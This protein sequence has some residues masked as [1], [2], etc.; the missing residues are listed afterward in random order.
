LLGALPLVG[1]ADDLA[2]I[3]TLLDRVED[4]ASAV[5]VSGAGGS[6]KTRICE[7]LA[8]RA[9]R[10]GW[11]VATGRAYPVEQG[12][13]FALFS[14]AFVEVLKEM[15]QQTLSVL[16]RG[17]E[18]ELRYL[19]P[20]LGEA[21]GGTSPTGF[22]DPDEL[23]TRV[24]WNFTEFLKRYAGRSPLLVVLE[25]LQ[26]ADASS[27]ELLHF[28]ARQASGHSLLFACTY[29]DTERDASSDLVR[30]ERSLLSLGQARVHKLEPLEPEH[31][32]ELVRRV[33][34]VDGGLVGE[35]SAELF[36]WTRG[37]PFFVE[38]TLKSLVA[39]GV[40]SNEKGTWVGWDARDFA[41]AESVRDAVI[42]RW[43]GFSENARAVGEL[44][45]VV[46]ARASYPLL[47]SISGLDE[48]A[49]L[50]ALEELVDHHIL[51]ELP[52]AGA[53]V[54]DFLHP[55]VRDT[56]YQEFGLQRTRLLHAAVAEAM[57]S[58]WGEEAMEHAEELA[59]HFARTD[60]ATLTQ[61]AVVYLTAAGRR[62]RARHAD[63]EAIAYFRAALDRVGRPESPED[64]DLARKLLGGLA[65]AHLRLGE[66]ESSASALRTACE[67]VDP[68]TAEHASL[69]RTLSLATFWCGRHKEALGLLEAALAS[70]KRGG[71]KAGWVRLRLVQGHCLQE[72][73]RGREARDNVRSALPEAEAL[74]DAE[75]LARV[76]RSLAMLA[77]WLGPPREAERSAQRAI[78]L[79]KEAG[80]LTIEFGARYSLGV[81]WGMTG[82]TTRMSEAIAEARSLAERLRSPVLRIWVAEL[83]IELA[84]ATGDWD[85][86][87]ALGEQSIALARTLNQSI[88][89][90]RV[91]VLTSLFH[92]GRGDF[93]RGKI[94]VD[95][96]CELSGLN[97]LDD[98]VDVNQVVPTFTGLATYKLRVG[99]YAGAIETAKRGMEVAEGTGYDLWFLHRLLPVLAEAC[100][101]AGEIDEAE[102]VGK[103]LRDLATRM[104]HRLGIAWADTCDALVQWK[105]GDI[106][107]GASAMREAAEK[108]EAI[109]MVPAAIRIRRQLAGRLAELGDTEGSMVEIRRVHDALARLGAELELEKARIQF[110]EIGLRPPPRGAGEGP[111][112]LTEREL[113]ISRLVARRKSNKAIGRELG[114]SDRTVS[115]H[116]SNIFQKLD[117][118]N[119][120]ELGDLIRELGLLEE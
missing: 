104:N 29:D 95:E 34:E 82:D 45:A 46:G 63:R 57:E 26:W 87:V 30:V 43:A 40:L 75:L 85:A 67:G 2:S 65:R 13:P 71:D 114:I 101:W 96:A 7:E 68:G 25:D 42:T 24:F 106:E 81:L 35:F 23:R 55:V 51:V 78:E 115:T 79:A 73:G 60:A 90:P 76:H 4:G 9:K 64:R 99:D 74:G 27:L 1:R 88:L 118:S 33:F 49:L 14:D 61:K 31:V 32:T 58:F 21:E 86:G 110:R 98:S 44:A 12:V 119:R 84:F 92:L 39:Q 102:T 53:V 107:G 120:T 93:D 41:L 83:A 3:G 47:R 10:E 16:S 77:V 17:G 97:R 89:L 19:F 80:D 105:R 94:L 56:L 54:Y 100:L 66:Y 108:L 116:L 117:A 69:M 52:A 28:V 50:A 11:E 15:D 59:Y 6:G 70:A 5:F 103:R 48:S 109:P 112:G 113:Q 72:L 36:R 37:N 111:S 8:A 22:G 20:V 91:L 18:A 38:E 62:A